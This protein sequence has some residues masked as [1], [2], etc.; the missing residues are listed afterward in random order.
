M[1]IVPFVAQ[2]ASSVMLNA[3]LPVKKARSAGLLF[4]NGFI[5]C[6]FLL[7]ESS[8]YVIAATVV[9][10][11]ACSYPVYKVLAAF[12]GEYCTF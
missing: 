12:N 9:V 3:R 10:L 1:S 2:A 11:L 8:G 6:L 4:L 5:V 7:S